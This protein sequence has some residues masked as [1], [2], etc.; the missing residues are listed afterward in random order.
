MY[1]V[2]LQGDDDSPL[3]DRLSPLDGLSK[4]FYAL[5]LCPVHNDTAASA[6]CLQHHPQL[7]HLLPHLQSLAHFCSASLFDAPVFSS[8]N[9]FKACT[10][11]SA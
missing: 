1:R 5:H 9:V 8:V 2:T 11:V 4:A 10:L 7:F 3:L 6:S